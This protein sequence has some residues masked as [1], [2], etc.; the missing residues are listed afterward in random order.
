M[1]DGEKLRKRHREDDPEGR[2]KAAVAPETPSLKEVEEFFEILR[3]VHVAVRYFDKRV[4]PGD[5]NGRGFSGRLMEALETGPMETTAASQE[6]MADEEPEKNK[7]L[8][9]DLNGEPDPDIAEMA[10]NEGGSLRGVPPD[11]IS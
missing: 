2:P 6:A 8:L 4:N 3:R 11:Q 9:F 1:E 5:G 7:V 10:V